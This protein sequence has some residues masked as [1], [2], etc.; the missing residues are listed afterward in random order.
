MRW[1]LVL[2]LN[3]GGDTD[4]SDCIYMLDYSVDIIKN[5]TFI[6]ILGLRVTGLDAF[7]YLRPPLQPLFF[8]TL[9]S[10]VFP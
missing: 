4:L 7:F 5:S 3:M 10:V 6:Y 1:V 9:A 8:F 2:V